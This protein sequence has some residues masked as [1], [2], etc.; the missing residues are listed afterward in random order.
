M[1]ENRRTE[2]MIIGNKIESG[3]IEW[4]TRQEIE[5]HRKQSSKQNNG[6]EKKIY[7]IENINIIEY[8]RQ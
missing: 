6:K 4:Q 3:K 5:E 8:V 2:N 1:T 7:V